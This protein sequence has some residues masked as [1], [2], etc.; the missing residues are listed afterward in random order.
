MV[1]IESMKIIYRAQKQRQVMSRLQLNQCHYITKTAI[2]PNLT[3]VLRNPKLHYWKPCLKLL[4]CY[5]GKMFC[6]S[7]GAEQGVARLLQY[8]SCALKSKV[9]TNFDE[10][11]VVKKEAAIS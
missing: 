10:T 4:L 3:F 8:L 1:G 9:V 2:L 5:T 7:K 6:Q 11:C